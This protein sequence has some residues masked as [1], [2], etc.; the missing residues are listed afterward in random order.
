VNCIESVE[1]IDYDDVDNYKSTYGDGKITQRII[2]TL[3]FDKKN[4]RI[5]NS[6]FCRADHKSS[7]KTI[8]ELKT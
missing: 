6:K 1:I 4:R 7:K 3:F 5:G 2:G 8:Y